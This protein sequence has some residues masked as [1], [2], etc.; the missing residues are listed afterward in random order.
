MTSTATDLKPFVR[1]WTTL[2]TTAKRDGSRFG[3]PV[4]LAVAGD[5]AYFRTY[6]TTWK[7]KRI[8]NNPNVEIVPSNL[9]GRPMGRP[10][11]GRARL[12]DGEEELHARKVIAQKYP[13]FQGILIPLG[14]RLARYK[15]VH[16]EVS[17]TTDDEP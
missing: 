17:L 9:R 5:H 8:R 11:R 6:D 3:T 7:T 10:V 12:L 16:Y 15:T 1:Q 2:L 13:V 4:N 14:H